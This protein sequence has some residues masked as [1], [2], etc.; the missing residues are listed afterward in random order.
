MVQIK[1]NSELVIKRTENKTVNLTPCIDVALDE[2][3][4]A[5]CLDSNSV[6]Y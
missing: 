5:S 4:D 3:L 6:S 2:E 1:N